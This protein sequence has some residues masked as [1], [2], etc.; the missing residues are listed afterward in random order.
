MSG[1]D[2]LKKC[3]NGHY[4]EKTLKRCPYCPPGQEGESNDN[5]QTVQVEDENTY[6]DADK[7]FVPGQQNEQETFIPK[8]ENFS[9]SQK[10]Y[11]PGL[12][13]S[14]NAN[15]P[16]NKQQDFTRTYIPGLEE[17]KQE[18]G[19]KKMV[20]SERQ[21]RKL[22]GWLV[23]YDIDPAGIDYRLFE[24]KNTIGAAPENQITIP[25]KTVSQRHAT[26]LYRNG[27]FR[28]KDEFST[29]GTYVNGVEVE[30]DVKFNDGD[31]IKVGKVNLLIRSA[32]FP[33]NQ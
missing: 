23:S 13:E 20:E 24:G 7:T 31:I 3:S 33:E 5:E 22:V 4:Y 9:E 11:I 16:Q 12:D 10:T 28:I 32:V 18:D 25:D 14:Y 26:I 27:K 15:E 19:S 29:A 30:E 21:Y 1:I 2:D 17:I 6:S 8:G